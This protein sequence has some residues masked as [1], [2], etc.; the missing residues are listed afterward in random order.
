MGLFTDCRLGMWLWA[1]LSSS[2]PALLCSGSGPPGLPGLPLISWGPWQ[3]GHHLLPDTCC[4]EEG[5]PQWNGTGW[6]SCP[7]QSLTR[8]LPGKAWVPVPR[9]AHPSQAALR[10]WWPCQGLSTQGCP[11]PSE[12]ADSQGDS[13]QLPGLP[14]EALRPQGTTGSHRDWECQGRRRKWGSCPGAGLRCS[15]GRPAGHSAGS[16]EAREQ[17]WYYFPLG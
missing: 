10:A 6:V 14:W 8:H 12:Q 2:V 5:F 4:R 3:L 16:E 7:Q 13:D 9:H 11:V 17:S 15:R 1:L